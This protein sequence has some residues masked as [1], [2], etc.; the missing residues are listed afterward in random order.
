LTNE[1]VWPQWL[2]KF[3]AYENVRRQLGPRPGWDD[4]EVV[5][6]EDGRFLNVAKPRPGHVPMLP[7]V[8]VKVVCGKCN[9]GWMSQ[10]EKQAGSVLQR[11]MADERM[12]LSDDEQEL[13]ALWAAKTMLLYSKC[14]EPIHQPFAEH[15]FRELYETRR[16]PRRYLLWIGRSDAPQAQV[17]MSLEPIL[18]APKDTPPK[19]VATMPPTAANL[20]LATHG[21]VIIGHFFPEFEEFDDDVCRLLSFDRDHRIGL[22]RLWPPRG[23]VRWPLRPIPAFELDAQREYLARFAHETAL[24]LAG[25]TSEEVVQATE[26]FQAGVEPKHIWEHF[27]LGPDQSKLHPSS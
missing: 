11:L 9:N 20:Y 18:W 13:L 10:L 27:G 5:T 1:H 24:P 3:P 17:A 15:A 6:D 22:Q 12:D 25:L 16:P 21:V 2:R 7:D 26:M 8:K 19:K 4:F 23:R 14:R